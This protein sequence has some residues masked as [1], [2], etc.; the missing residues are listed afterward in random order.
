MP[1]KI[2]AALIVMRANLQDAPGRSAWP[3]DCTV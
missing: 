2:C 3:G 1:A